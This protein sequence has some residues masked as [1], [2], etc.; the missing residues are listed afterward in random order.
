MPDGVHVQRIR[1]TVQLFYHRLKITAKVGRIMRRTVLIRKHK[2]G[3]VTIPRELAF[4]DLL[5]LPF[6]RSSFMAG[7]KGMTLFDVLVLVLLTN[8][9]VPATTT[10]A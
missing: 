2:I 5:L 9:G 4:G 7:G 8:I 10:R 3:F 1:A 6:R